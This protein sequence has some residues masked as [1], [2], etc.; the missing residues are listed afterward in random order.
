MHGQMNIKFDT[1]LVVVGDVDFVSFDLCR[2]CKD[3]INAHSHQAK[4]SDV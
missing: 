4:F 2:L 1:S 3:S